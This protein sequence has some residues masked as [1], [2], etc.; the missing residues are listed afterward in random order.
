MRI[1][2]G[3]AQ[4]ML[5]WLKTKL[6]LDA[7]STNARTRAVKRGQ[8]YRCNFGCGIGSEMQ[9]DRPAVIIQNDVGNNRSG[10][11]IVIPI[12]H[13]TSTLPCVANITPQ[14]DSSGNIIL[15]GQANASNMMCVS[16]ARLGD[17]VCALPSSDM[18]LIDEA[19]ARTVDLMGYYADITQKL[20]DKLNYIA[21]LKTDRNKA[22]DELAEI[23]KELGLTKDESLLNRISEMK[24]LL[25]ISG[26]TD[27]I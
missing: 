18:K 4:K 5:E 8:V 26:K 13:D 27:S 24:K 10:N 15:D 23:R 9:K 20:N 22:Q 12:T 25:T 3:Q 1:E 17:F 14:I 21:R 6:Y 11:T 16:K 7:L 2:L 19:I